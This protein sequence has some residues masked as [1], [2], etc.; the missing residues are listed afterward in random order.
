MIYKIVKSIMNFFETLFSLGQF[1]WGFVLDHVWA[2]FFA[3]FTPVFGLFY[4]FFSFLK[5]WL[6]SIVFPEGISADAPSSVLTEFYDKFITYFFGDIGF[7][8]D[9]LAHILNALAFDVMA[10]VI[11]TI[12]LPVLAG[13][14]SYRIAK[15]YLPFVS[16]V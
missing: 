12:V 11:F 15:S 10:E 2:F 3:V 9:I 16:G 6:V 7:F 13:V 4:A 8:G 5:S 1:I 14:M